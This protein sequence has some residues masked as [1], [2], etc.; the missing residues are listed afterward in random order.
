MHKRVQGAAVS[1]G[2]AESSF[3]TNRL[4]NV[5]RGADPPPPAILLLPLF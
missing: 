3:H 2:E 1:D 5:S 4:V